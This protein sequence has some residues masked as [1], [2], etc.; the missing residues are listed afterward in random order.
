MIKILAVLIFISSSIF[1]IS[2]E[3]YKDILKEKKFPWLNQ[4]AICELV[5]NTNAGNGDV[6]ECLKAADM[7][8]ALKGKK[9][10]ANALKFIPDGI[11]KYAA[12]SFYNAGV[13]Y[14]AHR[15]YKNEIIMYEKAAEQNYPDAIFNLGIAYG[16][17]K[18]V[19]KN[20]TKAYQYFK[21]ASALGDES[22]QNAIEIICGESPWACK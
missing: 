8:L 3:E 22:A 9:L 17:G 13:M 21:E 10:D 19:P 4:S 12:K 2:P 7:I 20:P 1:A 18:G 14:G 15:D 11:E 16:T 6:N 5:A